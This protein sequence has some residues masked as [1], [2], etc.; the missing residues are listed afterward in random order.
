[1]VDRVCAIGF[2]FQHFI[3]LHG[4]HMAIVKKQVDHF[5]VP[6][7][8]GIPDFRATRYCL[9]VAVGNIGAGKS[10]AGIEGRVAGR[11]VV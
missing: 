6:F 5:Q 11:S 7:D 4:L 8:Y 10:G 1:M 9:A 3:Y 2:P